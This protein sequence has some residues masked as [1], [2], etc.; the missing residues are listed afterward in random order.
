MITVPISIRLIFA[1]TAASKG[2]FEQRFAIAL[3]FFRNRSCNGYATRAC[4]GIDIIVLKT[5]F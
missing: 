3:E 1:P 4:Y 2:N 5:V